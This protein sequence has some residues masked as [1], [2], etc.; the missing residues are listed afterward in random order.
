[1]IRHR[2]VWRWRR[3]RAAHH[4]HIAWLAYLRWPDPVNQRRL[5][6]AAKYLD[7]VELDKPW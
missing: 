7:R 6:T 4:E 2:L 3:W 1:M 5:E